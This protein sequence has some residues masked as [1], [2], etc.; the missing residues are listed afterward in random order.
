MFAH[1]NFLVECFAVVLLVLVLDSFHVDFRAA[2]HDAGQDMFT[3]PLPLIVTN[4]Q[5]EMIL[6]KCQYAVFL[7]IFNV[8]VL[9][10]FCLRNTL[11]LHGCVELL[12]KVCRPASST[13]HYGHF[14]K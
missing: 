13:L 6:E 2:H 14:E 12:S 7:I 10:L 9:F 8:V 5:S 4:N 11:Y 1:Q 3:S